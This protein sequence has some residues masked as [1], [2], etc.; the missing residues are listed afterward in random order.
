MAAEAAPDVPMTAEELSKRV[1]VRGFDFGTTEEQLK[2]HCAAAGQVVTCEK[3]S[4]NAM[5]LT[6]SSA[7]EAQNAIATLNQTVVE[8][9][10]RYID[11][12]M[13]EGKETGKEKKPKEAGPSGPDLPRQRVT[14]API[15]GMVLRFVGSTGWIK[16]SETVEH[17]ELGRHKGKIYFHKNDLQGV[18][19]I[20]KDTSVAFHLYS[21]SAGLGAE[22]V[23][24][25]ALPPSPPPAAEK[26]KVKGPPPESP[27]P[28][29]PG[30]VKEGDGADAQAAEAKAKS[31]SK[32]KKK[33]KSKGGKGKS[34]SGPSGPDLER[35]RIGDSPISGSVL[36]FM[37]NTGWIKPSEDIDHP[38]FGKHQGKVYVH[39]KDLQG[40]ESL[41][42]D[43]NVVFHLYADSCGLGAEEVT[44]A[45]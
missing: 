22:E 21:D 18:E 7:A 25:V 4:N 26:P 42:K 10:T 32:K 45:L 39:K 2:A 29:A 30:T 8:G 36:R 19:S 37:G 13:D 11:V 38:E 43:M 6:Y 28:A 14:E 34:K 31:G 3:Q 1:F 12:K 41:E 17:P 33:K 27:P 44:L 24:V 23:T 15:P 35:Q 40:L 5:I 16:P 9:N 20:Q